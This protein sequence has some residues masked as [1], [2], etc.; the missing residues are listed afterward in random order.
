MNLII[1]QGN[2]FVKLALFKGGVLLRKAVF[3][4]VGTAQVKD[5]LQGENPA[6]CLVSTV[7]HGNLTG[8]LQASFSF[9]TY[10]LSATGP[11]PFTMRYETPETL[12]LDRVALA[13]AAVSLYPGKDCLVVDAGTSLTFDFVNRGGAYLGGAIA[14]GLQMRYRALHEFTA[15]L[16][17]V[18]HAAVTDFIGKSTT[19]CILSGVG[20]G[21][22]QEMKATIEQYEARFPEVITVVTGGDASLFDDLLKNGIFAAPDFLLKGLNNILDY[23]AETL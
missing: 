15:R 14:P 7:T 22:K 10:S 16:P 11:L 23:Y 2:T 21:M 8:L 5:F 6:R 3:Q 17:L 13:A 4:N 9:K 12:G 19:G 18:P 1:D 20:N